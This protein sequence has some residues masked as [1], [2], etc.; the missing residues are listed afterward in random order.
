MNQLKNLR[1][2]EMTTLGLALKNVFDILNINR[3]QSGIDTYGQ[4]RSPFFLEPCIIVVITDGGRLSNAS[5]VVD[6]FNLPMTNPIPGWEMTREPFRWDQR[7]FSLVLRMSGTPTVDRDTGLVANDTSPIDAMCEVT[8]GI[9][10]YYFILIN[11]NLKD[12][13]YIYV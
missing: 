7:L 12:L 11:S 13:K 4:G 6:E 5:N 1:C 9:N 8:G 10:Y 2:A 3:M